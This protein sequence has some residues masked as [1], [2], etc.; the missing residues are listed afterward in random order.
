[1]DKV[2]RFFRRTKTSSRVLVLAW[3]MILLLLLVGEAAGLADVDSK[4]ILL[5]AHIFLVPVLIIELCGNPVLLEND[6]NFFRFLSEVKIIS[7]T[8]FG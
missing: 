5:T 1:M 8:L 6:S 4:W 3:I 7:R 2:K